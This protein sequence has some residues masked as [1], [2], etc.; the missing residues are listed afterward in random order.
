ML[1]KSAIVVAHPDD[2][3]LWFSSIL[4]KVDSIIICFLES[5]GNAQ[6]TDGRKAVLSE[7][8][9]ENVHCLEIPLAE[10]FNYSEWITPVDSEFG[11][12]I[13]KNREAAEKYKENYFCIR[14][15]LNTKL[16]GYRNIFTH[17]PWGEYGHEEHVQVF[18]VLESLNGENDFT[19]WYSNYFSHRSYALMMKNID[20]ICSV[21]NS[22]ETDRDTSRNIMKLYIEKKCWTWFDSWEWPKTEYFFMDGFKDRKKEHNVK[23]LPFQMINIKPENNVIHKE[24]TIFRYISKR[25][26]KLKKKLS[27]YFK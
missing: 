9:L 5:Q 8:P 19:L 24:N 6:W 23:T 25:K 2:E 14:E 18:K 17:N 16:Q 1:E 3:I 7:Y 13:V 4:N 15:K 12:K 22:L 11:L 27:N 10:V 26:L 20:R 21:S